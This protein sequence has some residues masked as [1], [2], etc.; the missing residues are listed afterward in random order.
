MVCTTWHV[1]SYFPYQELNL[2]PLQWN[3]RVPAPGPPENSLSF[4]HFWI[5]LCVFCGW[6]VG[7]LYMFYILI[8]Y[9]L[10][11]LHVFSPILWVFF[12]LCWWYPS[13]FLIV[14]FGSPVYFFSFCCLCFW[15]HIQ[16]IIA[17]SSVMKLSPMISSKSFTVLVLTF[18]SLTILS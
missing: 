17:K 12:S 7:F 9:Q 1:V 8:T 6:I 15:C 14:K 18:R 13:V 16:E 3:C 4:A 5:G 10:Y 2:C 11:D